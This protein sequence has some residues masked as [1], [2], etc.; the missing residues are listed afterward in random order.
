MELISVILLGSDRA[1]KTYLRRPNPLLLH[2]AGR[3][4][5]LNG[6]N[7]NLATIRCG[8]KIWNQWSIHIPSPS[9][10][11]SSPS[12]SS[13]SS[14][15]APPFSSFFAFLASVILSCHAKNK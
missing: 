12:T 6:S 13:S 10:S 1:S 3:I 14:G 7:E 15:V 9:I 11:S 4:L 8:G 5:H 2:R